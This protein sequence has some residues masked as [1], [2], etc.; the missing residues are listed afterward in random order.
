MREV[1]LFFKFPKNELQ[2]PI[3]DVSC[4][5]DITPGYPLLWSVCWSSE[6]KA[7][8]SNEKKMID[9]RILLSY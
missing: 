4:F 7:S 9:N 1:K 3:Y 5:P 8:Q 2:W 6:N